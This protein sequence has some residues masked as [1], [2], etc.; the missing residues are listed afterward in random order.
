MG[1]PRVR[2]TVWLMMIAVAVVAICLWAGMSFWPTNRVL[3]AAR[4]SVPGIIVE[5]FHT[6]KFNQ[7]PAWEVRGIDPDGTE[8]LL[9]ISGSGE[10]LM[11]EAIAH[12]PPRS[13]V[14][15]YGH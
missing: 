10:V 8:W 5:S 2:F 7:T 1:Q 6:E 11:K 3:A 12:G 9:D 15:P 4:A 13:V 14:V